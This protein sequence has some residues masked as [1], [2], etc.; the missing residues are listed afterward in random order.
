MYR[1]LLAIRRH[2]DIKHRMTKCKK[3]LI[4]SANYMHYIVTKITKNYHKERFFL[5]SNADLFY[6]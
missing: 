5:V 2:Y 3:K 6:D 1:F 4:R